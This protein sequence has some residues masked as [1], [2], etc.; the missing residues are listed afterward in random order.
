MCRQEGRAIR[1]ALILPSFLSSQMP[2]E[3]AMY[4]TR[5]GLPAR[6]ALRVAEIGACSA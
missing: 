5:Q 6:A 4:M 2:P 3:S 1:P